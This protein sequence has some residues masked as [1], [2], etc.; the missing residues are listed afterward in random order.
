M[1]FY[2]HTVRPRRPNNCLM[3]ADNEVYINYPVRPKTIRKAR[4]H[5]TDEKWGMLKS[6]KT[7]AL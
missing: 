1:R 3:N 2:D 5:S 7:E 4:A 6:E